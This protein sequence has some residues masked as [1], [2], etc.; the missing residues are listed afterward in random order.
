MSRLALERGGGRPSALAPLGRLHPLFRDGAGGSKN[1]TAEVDAVR[2]ALA[3][4]VSQAG[5]S[6]LVV[7][8]RQGLEDLASALGVLDIVFS[9]LTAAAMFLCFFS[10]ISAMSTN[11][12]EQR[13]EIGVLLALGIRARALV[14]AYVHEAT[15][16]VMSASMCGLVIGIASSWVFGQQRALFTDQTIPLPIPWVLILTVI[17]VSALCGL[18]A[19]CIPASRFA[20]MPITQLLRAAM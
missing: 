12:M 19:A 20:K 16:L 11:V 7:D 2:D 17:V 5:S 8:V 13:R 14:R 1:T 9:G 18:L 4:A 6:W 10:L 15:L 3:S